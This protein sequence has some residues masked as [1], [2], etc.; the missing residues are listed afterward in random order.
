M[1]QGVLSRGVR[2]WGGFGFLKKKF[3]I[4]LLVRVW[5][6]YKP[7][8]VFRL[9]P[10]C[11]KFKFVL[12]TGIQLIDRK[13]TSHSKSDLK[14]WIFRSDLLSEVVFRPK[15]WIP[16]DNTNLNL[17]QTGLS[18][19]TRLDLY[20]A[21]SLSKRKIFDFFFKKSN[22]T[23]CPITTWKDS[24][25]RQHMSEK[26]GVSKKTVNARHSVIY[27]PCRDPIFSFLGSLEPPLAKQNLPRVF[28]SNPSFG[29]QCAN[30]VF[31]HCAIYTTLLLF[32]P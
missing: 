5:A 13:T 28:C 18:L 7:S 6:R 12:S 27:Q 16:V 17:L 24:L 8:L 26:R 2:H 14:I 11:S 3:E 4:S 25:L 10:V 20:L 31:W 23:V 30:T 22:V 15:S 29:P 21:L 32:L 19:K 1:Q 9:S